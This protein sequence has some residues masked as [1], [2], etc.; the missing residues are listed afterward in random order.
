MRGMPLGGAC[1]LHS[2]QTDCQ[3]WHSNLP[4]SARLPGDRAGLTLS[5]E[6]DAWPFSIAINEDDAGILKR[7]PDRCQ[8]RIICRDVTSFN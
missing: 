7:T 8:R 4:P 2:Q 6:P 3:V 5:G 1:H